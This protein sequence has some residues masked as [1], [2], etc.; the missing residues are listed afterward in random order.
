M[1]AEALT[2]VFTSVV[3]ASFI[4]VGGRFDKAGNG[5]TLTV[6][7]ALTQIDGLPLSH[8]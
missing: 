6:T 2:D 8:T 3:A 5:K 4:A 7:V 1:A